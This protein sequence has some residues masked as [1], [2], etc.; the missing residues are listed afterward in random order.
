MF[1]P[2]VCQL[3]NRS[4]KARFEVVLRRSSNPRRGK[5]VSSYRLASATSSMDQTILIIGTSPGLEC[6]TAA[7][8]ARVRNAAT[9]V[10]NTYG[11]HRVRNAESEGSSGRTHLLKR[12]GFW[13]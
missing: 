11:G 1:P 6:T 5:S 4:V 3:A 13:A 10:R 8:N 9:A 2:F 12:F 7:T